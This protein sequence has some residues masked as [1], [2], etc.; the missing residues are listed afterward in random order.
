MFILSMCLDF[1]VR[2]LVMEMILTTDLE[3]VEVFN[4]G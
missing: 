4:T 1:L 2:I 3:K